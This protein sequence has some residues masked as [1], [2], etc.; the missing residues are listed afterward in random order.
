M[1]LIW[2]G[3]GEMIS[4]KS[5]ILVMAASAMLGA[6]APTYRDTLEQRLAGKSLDERRVIL[7]KECGNEI[8]AGLNR[9]PDRARHFEYVKD[10][11]EELSGKPV[12][13]E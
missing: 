12:I 1:Q 6:C 9:N 13:V 2:A 8:R 7:A 5:L 4:A 3:V 10:V 11:C